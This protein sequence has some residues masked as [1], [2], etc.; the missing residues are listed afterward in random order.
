M[1]SIQ[2]V[3]N[4][5]F[6]FPLAIII[7]HWFADFFLQT[8]QM[9]KGKSKSFKWLTIHVLVY[10]APLLI[11]GWKFAAINGLAHWCTDAVTSKMTSKLWAKGDVH[12]FFVV[13]GADQ[14]IHMMTLFYTFWWLRL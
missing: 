5:P 9:A 8:D 14:A 11:F 6:L 10:S 12:N 7:V 1:D 13:I 2:I 3:T 4:W